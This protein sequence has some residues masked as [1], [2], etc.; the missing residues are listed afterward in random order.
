MQFQVESGIPKHINGRGRKAAPSRFP[1]HEMD[2]GDSF[3]I[4]CDSSDKK[5]VDSWRRKLL[6]AKKRMDGGRWETAVVSD[7][8]RVWRTA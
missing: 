5:V 8:I 4:P 1:L 6:T 3:L 7:G 2:V